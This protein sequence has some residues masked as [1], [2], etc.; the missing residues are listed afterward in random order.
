METLDICLQSSFFVYNDV[1]YKQ[2]F[3]CP[4]GS[5]LSP[6]IANMVMEENEKTALNTYLKP[7]FLWVRHVNDVCYNGKN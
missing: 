5:L 7:S 3:G 2:I 6:I 4:I 1:I